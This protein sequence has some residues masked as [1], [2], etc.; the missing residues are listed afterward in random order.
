MPPE[1]HVQAVQNAH[2]CRNAAASGVA[3]GRVEAGQLREDKPSR[4]VTRGSGSS[5]SPAA[6]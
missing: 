5:Q 2:N 6:L 3:F 1:R 4:D